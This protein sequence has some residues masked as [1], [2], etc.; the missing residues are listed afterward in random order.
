LG[1]D[2]EFVDGEDKV[3]I[4]FIEG[5]SA[6]AVNA[7]AAAMLFGPEGVEPLLKSLEVCSTMIWEVDMSTNDD[8][9]E[10]IKKKQ[11]KYLWFGY[12]SYSGP[13]EAGAFNPTNL[14]ADVSIFD[15]LFEIFGVKEKTREGPEEK[16]RRNN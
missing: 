10:E 3:T 15:K 2:V 4:V 7:A 9:P 6:S 8:N 13:G 16:V 5:A 11:R 14:R 1:A 12:G